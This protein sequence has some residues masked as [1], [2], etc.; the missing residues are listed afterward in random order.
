[1]IR[2]G[3]NLKLKKQKRSRSRKN[4]K[5]KKG[6]KDIVNKTNRRRKLGETW[7][8]VLMGLL[9]FFAQREF[10]YICTILHTIVLKAN[11]YMMGH[12]FASNQMKYVI[13]FLNII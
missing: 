13:F 12:E 9:I 2:K 5:G 11:I 1:M 8:E 6:V 4:V 3:K 7:N 10:W